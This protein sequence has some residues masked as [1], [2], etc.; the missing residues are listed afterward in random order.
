MKDTKIKD[1]FDFKDLIIMTNELFKLIELSYG[2]SEAKDGFVGHFINVL[3]KY[4]PEVTFQQIESAFEYNA[5]GYLNEYLPKSGYSIDNKVKFTI[6]DLTK[7]IKAYCKYKNL[8]TDEKK[9]EN[10]KSEL[11]IAEIDFIWRQKLNTI[12][13]TYMNE[14]I[15][16]PITMPV[17]YCQYL[18]KLGLLDAS[19]IDKAEPSIIIAFGKSKK[20]K[21]THNVDLIYRCFDTLLSNGELLINY[22]N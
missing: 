3:K 7:I 1:I 8:T 5:A 4:H 9:E 11:E 12:F 19:K 18:A 10:G 22:L 14:F 6:P 2:L 21:N 16:S 17:F 13:E 15:V 20:V